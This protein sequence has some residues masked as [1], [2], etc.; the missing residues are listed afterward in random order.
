MAASR[1]KRSVASTFW[2]EPDCSVGITDT[3]ATERRGD[4]Y[5]GAPYPAGR[6]LSKPK[7]V[8]SIRVRLETQIRWK[9]NCVLF[10]LTVPCTGERSPVGET[11][12][13]AQGYN[14]DGKSAE[15]HRQIRKRPGISGWIG[16]SSRHAGRSR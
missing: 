10:G 7:H 2:E 3:L 13:G 8:S 9:S 15:A 5:G 14:F 4:Q 12:S 1:Q 16:D 11:R 6:N